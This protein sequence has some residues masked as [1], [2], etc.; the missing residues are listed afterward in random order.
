MFVET[1][2]IYVN[3]QTIHTNTRLAEQIHVKFSNNSREHYPCGTTFSE[4]HLKYVSDVNYWKNTQTYVNYLKNT[5]IR[6]FPLKL[7]EHSHEL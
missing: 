2:T 7:F 6:E 5:N 4:I 1:R 3:L